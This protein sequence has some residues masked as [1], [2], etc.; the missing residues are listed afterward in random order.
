MGYTHYYPLKKAVAKTKRKAIISD[1][2][3]IEA[4]FDKIGQPLFDGRGEKKGVV[5]M[6]N[7]FAF[8]GNGDAAHETMYIDFDDTD[9]NFCKTACKPYDDAV[10]CVLMMLKA[11]LDKGIRVSGDGGAEGFDEGISIYYEIFTDNKVV[12]T[13]DG[14]DHII[15]DKKMT[16]LGKVVEKI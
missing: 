4:H 7:G 10:C 13:H 1:M 6:D 15:I 9:F 16:A 5:Y 14:E 11:H 12:F 8:N 3:K 2:K